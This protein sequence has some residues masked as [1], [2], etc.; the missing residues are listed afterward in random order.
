[1][2]RTDLNFKAAS[3]SCLFLA[4]H[5]STAAYWGLMLLGRW[6]WVRVISDFCLFL[7]IDFCK[8]LSYKDA[9]RP[10]DGQKAGYK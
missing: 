5:E 9:L 6:H 3:K 7:L 4:K 2:A 10:S 1:M 8:Y